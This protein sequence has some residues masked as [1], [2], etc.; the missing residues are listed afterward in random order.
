MAL[1]CFD[2]DPFDP[3]HLRLCSMLALVSAIVVVPYWGVCASDLVLKSWRIMAWRSQGGTHFVWG[4]W[5]TYLLGRG[6]TL[7][8]WEDYINII[9]EVY[10]AKWCSN[11]LLKSN[12]S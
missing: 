3:L 4:L 2:S 9:S 10:H 8:F 6:Q 1:I 7:R 12:K 5:W 11:H